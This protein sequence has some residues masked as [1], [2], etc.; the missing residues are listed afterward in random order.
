MSRCID[1]RFLL[2]RN[3]LFTGNTKPRQAWIEERMLML[4]DVFAIDL[5]SYAIM[6][7][8][9]HSVLHVNQALM[10][11]WSNV[12]ILKRWSKIGQIP[13]LCQLY[14]HREW[15]D[16]LS[17]GELMMVLEQVA[18]YRRKLTDISC[19]MSKLNSYIS[20]R[21]NKEDGRKGHF[22]EGRFKSQAL[23][24]ANS[25]YRCM[26]Y[27]DLNPLRAGKCSMIRNSNYTS[28]IWRLKRSVDLRETLLK[29]IR[30]DYRYLMSSVVDNVS[31]HEYMEYMESA[32]NLRN[33]GF[34]SFT[35]SE[36]NWIVT[37][38]DFEEIYNL[39]AGPPELVASFEAEVRTNSKRSKTA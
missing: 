36:S 9:T 32:L 19:F 29:P 4:A 23:L 6:D 24:D 17:D 34:D 3:L 14:V 22:W 13:V 37:L 1:Q 27:V 20:H 10:K 5:L 15:R 38:F 7:N 16:K 8:H 18:I 31:V 21:A 39:S 28:I 33:S 30:N 25:V 2:E 11:Q 35:Q 12:E 26:A